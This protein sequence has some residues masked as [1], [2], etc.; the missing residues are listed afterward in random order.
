MD[1][2]LE[3]GWRGKVLVL[4]AGADEL[5]PEGQAREI[6]SIARKMVVEVD[7]VTVD[8]ALHVEC[9]SRPKGRKAVLRYLR[10]MAGNKE[11]A[12]KGR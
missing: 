3:W 8:G 6:V 12:S 5:V 2:I 9:L 4:E 10:E 7:L 1:R 11:N